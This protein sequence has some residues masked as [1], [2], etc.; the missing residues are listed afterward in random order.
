MEKH[1]CTYITMK[2]NRQMFKVVWKNINKLT[3]GHTITM[4]K[5]M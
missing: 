2:Y 5:D 4:E 1:M 3:D